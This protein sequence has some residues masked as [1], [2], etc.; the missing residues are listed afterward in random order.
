[1]QKLT[2]NIKKRRENAKTRVLSF[3]GS[4]WT[5]SGVFFE[6]RPLATMGGHMRAHFGVILGV[7][8]EV[9]SRIKRGPNTNNIYMLTSVGKHFLKLF[10]GLVWKLW[11]M[12]PRLG[13]REAFET[14]YSIISMYSG[15]GKHT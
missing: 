8:L 4:C 12:F 2:E 5:N 7:V 9:L 3:L 1:M 10:W 15:F 11:F 14:L 6:V 13:F